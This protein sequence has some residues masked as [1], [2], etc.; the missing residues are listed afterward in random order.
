MKK[1]RK[2]LLMISLVSSF[3]VSSTLVSLA[4]TWEQ[5]TN[6]QYKYKNDDGSYATSC[7]IDGY[8][9]NSDG[10]WIE[11]IKSD[12]GDNKSWKNEEVAEQMGIEIQK[13]K[14]FTQNPI[15]VLDN[16]ASYGNESSAIKLLKTDDGY[17]F[18]LKTALTGSSE[19]GFRTLCYLICD[20]DTLFN[21]IMS[22]Y[23]N[24]ILQN[25]TW[26]KTEYGFSVMVHTKDGMITYSIKMD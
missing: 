26:T 10:I 15:R 1:I 19:K 13:E 2:A 20:D 21:Y 4:G 23:Q 3:V 24:E 6:G 5:Q 9:L 14:E 17:T 11:D 22:D 18:D 7:L 25:D 12:N 16:S 8:Y